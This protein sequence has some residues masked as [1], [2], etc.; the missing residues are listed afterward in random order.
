[1]NARLF[2]FLFRLFADDL[3]SLAD[4][5]AALRQLESQ[6]GIKRVKEAIYG[7]VALARNN[8]AHELRGERVDQVSVQVY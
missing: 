3:T 2:G 5:D 6:T 7:I 1:M 8:Y 4:L